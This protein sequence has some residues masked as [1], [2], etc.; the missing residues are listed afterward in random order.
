MVVKINNMKNEERKKVTLTPV[1]SPATVIAKVSTALESYGLT[2]DIVDL[3][4]E[5]VTYEIKVLK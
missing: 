5:N 3:R 4:E 1:D 2:I